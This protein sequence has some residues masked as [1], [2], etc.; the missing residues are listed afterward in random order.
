MQKE[1]D[2]FNDY[3]VFEYNH[4]FEIVYWKSDDAL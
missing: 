2:F 4:D 1:K 3:N